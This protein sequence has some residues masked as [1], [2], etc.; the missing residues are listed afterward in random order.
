M[1]RRW[2][3]AAGALGNRAVDVALWT[4]ALR[5]GARRSTSLASALISVRIRSSSSL[6]KEKRSEHERKMH[7]DWWG[8]P[9]I[10]WDVEGLATGAIVAA[11]LLP[12]IATLC[13]AVRA[14]ETENLT[15]G[16]SNSLASG[17]ARV[18]MVFSCTLDRG[19][20]RLGLT[21]SSLEVAARRLPGWKSFFHVAFPEVRK[22]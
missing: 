8:S 6:R 2:P 14:L 17:S 12:V 15:F 11:A 16:G 13:A 1:A 20:V 9:R 5:G 10:H 18:D 22:R 7:G 19:A 4:A 21:R 3:R